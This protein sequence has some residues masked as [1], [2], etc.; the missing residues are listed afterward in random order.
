MPVV[1]VLVVVAMGVD[2]R[3]SGVE[4]RL[5]PSEGLSHGEETRG[6]LGSKVKTDMFTVF[7]LGLF[8]FG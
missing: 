3:T 8:R 2:E 4:R 5:G 7:V 1:V 6:G